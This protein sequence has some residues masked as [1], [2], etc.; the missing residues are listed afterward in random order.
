MSKDIKATEQRG[1]QAGGQVAQPVTYESSLIMREREFVAR[2][3][4][5]AREA[6][7]GESSLAGLAAMRIHAPSH[8]R[9]EVSVAI[10]FFL[11]VVLLVLDGGLLS[12]GLKLIFFG[13]LC[14]FTAV[15]FG[16]RFSGSE[17]DIRVWKACAK[18]YADLRAAH[19]QLRT[20]LRMLD[21]VSA[22]RVIGGRKGDGYIYYVVS[23]IQH[24]MEH[25]IKTAKRAILAR[26]QSDLVRAYAALTAPVIIHD[27]VSLRGIS[28]EIKV[29]ELPLVS[30]FFAEQLFRAAAPKEGKNR[31]ARRTTFSALRGGRDENDL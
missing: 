17:K 29:A 26:E 15:V 20:A 1:T 5:H 9:Y 25:R 13:T 24:I 12:P 4:A 3:I 6:A 8:A 30:Q 18:G 28:Y 31:R 14:A 19:R 21:E 22:Y 11:G 10:L 7:T 16:I 2:V 23:E 27:S